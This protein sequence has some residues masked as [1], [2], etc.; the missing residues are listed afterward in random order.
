MYVRA[1]SRISTRL[2]LSAALY[3]MEQQ[4]HTI[5][6]KPNPAN[7]ENRVSS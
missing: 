5:E 6:I 2:N 7:M 3:E 1:E 4:R